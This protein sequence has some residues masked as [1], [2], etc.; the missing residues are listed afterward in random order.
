MKLRFE[1][2][3]VA[4][5]SSA[6]VN[7]QRLDPARVKGRSSGDAASLFVA[8]LRFFSLRLTPP[9]QPNEYDFHECDMAS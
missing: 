6:K 9:Q 1:K 3:S 5:L 7:A 4:A 8:L 2:F